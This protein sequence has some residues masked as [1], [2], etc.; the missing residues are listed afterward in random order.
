MTTHIIL[1]KSQQGKKELD[2]RWRGVANQPPEV[3]ATVDKQKQFEMHGHQSNY[4]SFHSDQLLSGLQAKLDF[5]TGL[6]DEMQKL[7]S[8]SLN[9]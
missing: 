1:I 3:A 9:S 6:G 2:W 5:V 7:R 8:P 4:L